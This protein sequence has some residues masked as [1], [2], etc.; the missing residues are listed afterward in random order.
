[1]SYGESPVGYGTPR[2]RSSGMGCLVLLILGVVFLY[3][4]NVNLNR[5]RQDAPPDRMGPPRGVTPAPPGGDLLPPR[6]EIPE[7]RQPAQTTTEGDWSIEEVEVE[8]TPDPDGGVEIVIP[9]ANPSITPSTDSKR[10]EQGDWS[11]E[12]VETQGSS[13]GTPRASD[14]PATEQQPPKKTQEGDWEIEE[15][16]TQNSDSDANAAGEQPPAEKAPPKKTQEGDWEIEEVD[17]DAAAV[18]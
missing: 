15:I 12:E 3:V 1:M 9:P 8:Q 16:E 4:M 6:I 7:D 10:T 18:P 14:A 5:G 13:N 2:R 17:S 11:I